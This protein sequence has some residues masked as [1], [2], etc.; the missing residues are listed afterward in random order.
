MSGSPRLL[1]AVLAGGRSRRF[2]RDKAV[3]IVGGRTLVERAAGT[4][5]AVCEEVVVVSPHEVGTLH[6]RVADRRPG[7]G[8][9]GALETALEAA[10]E[11]G[12]DGVLVLACDLPLV[13]AGSVRALAAALRDA[14]AAA[15]A[16]DGTPPVEPLC[17]A[18]R[19]ECLAPARAL[20]E[21]GARAAQALFSEVGGCRLPLP[22]EELLNVN[23]EGDAE[24]A[25]RALS[26]RRA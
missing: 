1:G 3:E 21:G 23:T 13:T 5:D 24:R 22:R 15:A 8:P 2:G 9:L 18:Y 10:V 12:L 4:L 16:R 11:R 19:S 26:A 17:A 25:E 14:P 6:R 7:W 20:V